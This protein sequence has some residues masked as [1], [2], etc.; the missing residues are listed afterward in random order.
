MMAGIKAELTR[1][2]NPQTATIL[3]RFF[4]TGPGEYGEGDRFRG[5]RVP[6][7]RQVAK[8]Y[9][10]LSRVETGHLLQSAFHEDRL[11]AL[12]I[13]ID[14]YY[15]GQDPVRADIHHLYLQYTRF[16]NNWDL[17]DVSAPHLVGHYL[18]NRPKD[19]LLD[20]ATS[21]VLWER[22]LA[23]IATLA[24]I[25]DGNF[26]ETFRIAR[27]LLEDPEDL[28]HK[29]VGWMLRE[30]GKREMTVLYA[31]LQAHCRVMPRTMLRYA[32]EKFP[33][34]RR[35]AFLRGIVN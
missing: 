19:K 3:Q 10:H 4:K 18:K 33:E 30:V 23:I 28:I 26:D 1:L 17:V 21:A 7:L 25:K 6:V 11:L 12:L 15:Q 32:I 16:V 13:F 29:A 35:Q 2:Q 34:D 8:K 9:R 24:F 20:L 22:R 5:I 31:F 14:H 27:V